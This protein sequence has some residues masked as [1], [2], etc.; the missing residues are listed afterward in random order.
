MKRFTVHAE[1]D[2][3]AGVWIGTNEQLPLTTEAATF[4]RLMA[5]VMEIAPEIAA[6][7]GHVAKGEQVGIHFTADR[8]A[9]AVP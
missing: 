1:Y 4:D 6:L 9:A 3:E 7:N 5:R 8:V 2:A